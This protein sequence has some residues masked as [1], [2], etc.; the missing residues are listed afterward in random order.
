M[1]DWRARPSIAYCDDVAA[2]ACVPVS[3]PP[4]LGLAAGRPRR[5]GRRGVTWVELTILF[6]LRSG[7]ALMAASG[8]SPLSI[9]AH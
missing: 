8:A 6:E 5:P 1:Q 2:A 4:L 9:R 7:H 3:S